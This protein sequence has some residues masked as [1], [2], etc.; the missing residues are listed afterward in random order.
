[1]T[2]QG[3]VVR[4]ARRRDGATRGVF[5]TSRDTPRAPTCNTRKKFPRQVG[6]TWCLLGDVCI[7]HSGAKR[8]GISAGTF[9]FWGNLA[10]FKRTV[11]AAGA[12]FPTVLCK[13]ANFFAKKVPLL[14]S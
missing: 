12:T 7:I 14:N 6:T 4:D 1:M 11:P 5:D 10:H 13:F 3:G 2:F 9:F 8:A